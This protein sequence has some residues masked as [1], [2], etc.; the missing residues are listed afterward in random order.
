MTRNDIKCDGT[1]V[2]YT[3]HVHVDKKGEGRGVFQKTI[4]VYSGVGATVIV[5]MVLEGGFKNNVCLLEWGSM[6]PKFREIFYILC[7]WPLA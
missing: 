2:S 6:G 3:N 7:V 1:N 5:N 4:L